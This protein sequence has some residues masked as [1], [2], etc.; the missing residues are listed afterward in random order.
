MSDS[1]KDRAGLLIAVLF[2]FSGAGSLVYQVVWVR[3]LVLVFGTTVFAVSTVLS[4]FMAGLA[5]GSTYFG[6]LVDRRG[7]GLRIYAGLEL[8]IGVCALLLLPIFAGLDSL[9]TGAYRLL[10]GHPHLFTLFRFAL[11]FLVLLVP[12]T[13]IGGTLPV[14]SKFVVRRLPRVGR[15]VGALYAVNT[16]GA[17]AG[18]I[19]VAFVL[20]ERLGIRGTVLVAAGVNLLIALVAF[21]LSMRAEGL[22]EADTVEEVAPPP[23][24]AGQPLAG[25]PA[26]AIRAVFWGYAVS[27]FVALGYEVVWT[28]LLSI[29][30]RSTTTQSLSTTLIVFLF[31]LAAGGAVAARFV[32]RWR[33]LLPAFGVAELLLGL[34]GLASVAVF[35]SI[36]DVA[37]ALG[38]VYSFWGHVVRLVAVACVA[39]LIPTFLMGMLFPIAGKLYVRALASVGR[40]VGGIYAA[41][42]TGAIFGAFAAGFVLI[43]LLGS[44]WSIQLLAWV[45]IAVGVV[46]LMLDPAMR[47]K[48]R[49]VAISLVGIPALLLT[50]LLPSSF[51]IDL[52]RPP[53][54]SDLLYHDEGAAGTVTVLEFE[55]GSRLLRVNGAG[56]VPTDRASIQIFRLLGSLPLLTHPAPEDVLVIA[57]GGGITL[58][59]VELQQPGQIDCVEVVPGVVGAAG[60]FAEYNNRVFERLE[61]DRIDLIADDGRNH[62]LRTPETY[63]VIISDSTHPRTAD[64]WVLYT[65]DFYELC[66]RRLN[67]GGYIAQWVPLHG[68]T[69]DD[70]RMIVRT[71]RSVFPHCSLWLNTQYTVLLGA[72]EPLRIEFDRLRER[73]ASGPAK[74]A[75]DEVNLGDPVSLLGTLA[76]DEV[77]LAAYAG[78][79]PINTDNRAHINFGDRLRTHTTGGVAAMVSLVPH[80]SGRVNYVVKATPVESRGLQRRL[81]SRAHML[82][83][84][85]AAKLG[86]RQRAVQE[87]RRARQTDAG[88]VEAQRILDRLTQGP[89]AGG[90]ASAAPPGAR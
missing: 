65:R 78:E 86:D 19:A 56:E 58:A 47:T 44:Q 71:F 23:V 90:P 64:S 49:A 16:F 27:G 77:A 2:F 52:F 18:T 6:R 24:E 87:L 10:E 35:R 28:R 63:D 5:L 4:A 50:F 13:L 66:K 11:S 20:L 85:V 1:G 82:V 37:A 84:F 29:V 83:G 51:L 17:A 40:R 45:N 3:M 69:A 21:L 14:L 70:Y 26:N 74:A 31:G 67:A 43:P 39:M 59:S 9:Y 81:R 34:Y 12:T 88:N 80:L 15:S 75:L 73:L 30:M 62:V 76:L 33:R 8:L 53:A 57:F 61:A 42:T 54:A 38:P 48:T 25:L 60:Y 41:N 46:V 32:D 79:G 72:P 22:A 36:P 89:R 55:N 7:D 68:L